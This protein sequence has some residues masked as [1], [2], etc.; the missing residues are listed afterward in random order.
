MF[1]SVPLDAGR[2]LPQSVQKIKEPIAAMVSLLSLSFREAALKKIVVGDQ[3]RIEHQQMDFFSAACQNFSG[4]GS[5]C[6]QRGQTQ[7]AASGSTP[8]PPDPTPGA[9]TARQRLGED[10]LLG[11]PTW[12]CK[13]AC[14]SS[15]G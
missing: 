3:S 15:L 4:A 14:G 2:R 8:I 13:A 10:G 5:Q 6:N 9:R 12:Q 7:Q 1:F 11:G